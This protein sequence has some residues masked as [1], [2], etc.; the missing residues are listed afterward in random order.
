MK[1]ELYNL[2]K[3]RKWKKKYTTLLNWE[4]ERRSIQPYSIEKMKEEVYNLAKLRKWKKNYT[5]LLN[6][7]NKRRTIQPY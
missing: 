2:T 7:E 6:W 4:N 3:L 5:T 1:E